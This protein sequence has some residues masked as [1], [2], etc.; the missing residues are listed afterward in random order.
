MNQETRFLMGIYQVNVI[1]R[2]SLEY[3]IPKSNYSKEV[4]E[5]RKA[6]ILH[7]LEDNA[8]LIHFLKQ[9]K[10]NDVGKSIQNNIN[11]FIDLI[12]GNDARVVHTEDNKLIVDT[13][14]ATQVFDY[15]VGLHETI[16][17]ILHGF[18][19]Y[20]KE[21]GTYEESFGELMGKDDIFYRSITYL[22][23]TD[24]LARLF[25]E[26]NKTMNEAKGKENPQSSFVINEIRKVIGFLNFLDEH[27]HIENEKYLKNKELSHEVIDLMSGSKKPEEG[28]T[29]PMYITDLHNEWSKLC[30][31]TE[32][33][34]KKTYVEI[35]QE[36]SEFEEKI[37]KETQKNEA[38]N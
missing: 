32:L 26:F 35:W 2:D 7:G 9:Q 34:W 6:S 22:V 29:I 1:I 30:Q 3:G 15:V 31:V 8:P 17:D 20:N 14:F 23:L 11:D 4:Y 38:Q 33:D 37:L 28:K 36:L 18:I 24:S 21:H 27:T 12:Y 25:Q 10:E 13:A 16:N 19:N 5:Q